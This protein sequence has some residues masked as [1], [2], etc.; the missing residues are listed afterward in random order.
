[1]ILA[2]A[3]PPTLPVTKSEISVFKVDDSTPRYPDN[4]TTR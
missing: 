4:Q 1:M 3:A 2:P